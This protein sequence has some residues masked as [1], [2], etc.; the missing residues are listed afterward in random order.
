[1]KGELKG[2]IGN[3]KIIVGDLHTPL[4]ITINNTIL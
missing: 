4:S 2:E 3:S 1:M